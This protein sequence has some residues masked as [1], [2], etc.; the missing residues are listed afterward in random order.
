MSTIC[1]HSPFSRQLRGQSS[2]GQGLPQLH[3][4]KCGWVFLLVASSRA[5]LSSIHAA[6]ARW[7]SS[8]GELRTII[9]EEQQTSRGV[10]PRLDHCLDWTSYWIYLFTYYR[11]FTPASLSCSGDVFTIV[12][13]PRRYLQD[14][15]KHWLIKLFV[16]CDRFTDD[17][18]FVCTRPVLS[19]INVV[20]H[21][22]VRK[23]TTFHVIMSW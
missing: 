14:F 18:S 19:V 23:L 13:V 9:A 7:W 8:R 10:S 22:K 6:R 15:V 1:R 3:A 11:Q 4:A 20:F 12:K 17:H 5:V 21:M 16:A 2:E